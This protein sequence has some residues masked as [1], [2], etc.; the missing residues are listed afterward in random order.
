MSKRVLAAVVAA[1]AVTVSV[2]SAAPASA[3]PAATSSIS[4]TSAPTAQI[5]VYNWLSVAIATS[6][7]TRPTG[8]VQFFNS[9]GQ[10]IGSATTSASGATGATASI[11][12]IPTEQRTYTFTATFRSDNALVTGSTTSAPITIQATPNGQLVSIAAT[13][14]YRG[15]P[16][17]LVATVY[18]STL[19]GS[20]AFSVNQLQYGTGPSVPIVNGSASQ[21]FIPTGIGW[22]QFIVELHLHQRR[23]RAGR[24][25]AMGQR[26]A[27][28]RNR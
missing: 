16:T 20:V 17:T 24:C 28:A 5:G 1:A 21:T 15:I 10:L 3:V 14:M 2:L 18:P 11:P 19:Q 7:G 13:Q 6:D 26:A 12:W 23:R 4:F 8:G 27:S 22:Q 9:S 25:L